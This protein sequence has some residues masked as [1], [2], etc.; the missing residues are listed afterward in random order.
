VSYRG[1]RPQGLEPKP[2]P[3]LVSASCLAAVKLLA[4]QPAQVVVAIEALASPAQPAVFAVKCSVD[5]CLAVF[6]RLDSCLSYTGYVYTYAYLTKTAL[7][8]PAG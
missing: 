3:V 8:T 6:G 5:Q 2:A 4:A 7:K 1:F